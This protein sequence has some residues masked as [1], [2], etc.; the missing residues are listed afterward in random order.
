VEPVGAVAV[1]PG[2]RLGGRDRCLP[3]EQAPRVAVGQ[4]APP[5]DDLVDLR[6]VAVVHRALSEDADV[7][8]V[9]L[10]GRGVVAQQGVLDDDVADVDPEAGH[11]AVEPVGDDPVELVPHL[12][13][14]PVEVR[15]LDEV[16]VEV[17]LAGALV[18]RPRRPPEAG[19]SRCRASLPERASTNQGCRS[20]VW[21]GTRS[22]RTRIPR[23]PASAIR[24][25]RSSRVPSSGSTA[26]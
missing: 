15:L 21:F 1:V 20:L 25:S 10:L 23:R 17:V 24:R 9:G 22:R 19:Q 16:V 13:V 4:A 12:L 7:Q 14:P 11:P 2:E 8:R 18:E 6:P 5:S 3:Q 26:R